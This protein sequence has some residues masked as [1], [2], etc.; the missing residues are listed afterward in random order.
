MILKSGESLEVEV[1][2]FNQKEYRVIHHFSKGIKEEKTI[3][4]ED[5]LKV[6]KGSALDDEE[7][8]KLEAYLPVPD[9]KGEEYYTLLIEERFEAFLED[10]PNSDLRSRVKQDIKD[11][12]E[13]REQVASGAMK[14][15]GKFITE[16]DVE[17]QLFDFQ[18]EQV[19][20]RVM[21]ALDDKKILT[22]LRE[23]E[24]FRD[25]YINSKAY[26]KT[27]KSMNDTLKALLVL[28]EK[29]IASP[30][31]EP[32]EKFYN[33]LG[34]NEEQRVKQEYADK[35]KRMEEKIAQ[36]EENGE[37]WVSIDFSSPSGMEK[38]KSLVEDRIKELDEWSASEK[39]DG[40]SLYNAAF[41]AIKVEDIEGAK[42]AI[43]E[44]SAAA[45]PE[46][47]VSYLNDK[48]S[49]LEREIEARENATEEEVAEE[50][51]SEASE[52]AAVEGE[53][54]VE[55]EVDPISVEELQ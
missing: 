4:A 6:K 33:S 2:D 1:L 44:F 42:L 40:G 38:T 19:R 54:V 51:S 45:P 22:A 35:K 34:F 27:A 49:S 26:L 28:L 25:G 32:D 21:A 24:G 37:V 53:E 10:F 13:E 43:E 30:D 31:V 7:Y 29:K 23:Y 20:G 52:E 9:G 12:K 50:D 11:L 5:V 8:E 15:K 39:I 48:V 17:D 18:A 36:D 16:A 3:P 41:L 14:Y 47:L 46:V 55:P